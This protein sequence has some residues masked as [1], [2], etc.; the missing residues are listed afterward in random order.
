MIGS[1]RA[2]EY[3]E[4]TLKT[5]KELLSEHM[6]GNFRKVTHLDLTTALEVLKAAGHNLAIANWKG[7]KEARKKAKA[8]N[9]GFIFGMYENK[10]IQQAKTKYDWDCTYDEAHDFRTAY[11]EL[12][13]G[14][15]PWHNKQKTI[16]KIDGQVRNLF[17][18]VRRLPGVYSSD[19]E[20]RG[21]AERQ[22]INSPVQGT[23]GDWKS[24]A[25]VEIEET[26]PTS[27]LRIV[28]E[29][30]DALLMIFRPQYR[31]EVLPRVRAIMR[32]PKLFDEFKIST[33]VPM[34]SE[35][36]IGNWGA[37]K[38]YEDPR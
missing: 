37:G 14:V 34:E 13:Q 20:L 24:A 10:F 19:R 15:I 31:D 25:L 5:A 17:G 18:R 30:H 12:Y 28:G 32:R 3:T 11:F 22:A 35:I 26:I 36:E 4:Q 1:G 27:K 21:E 33:V 8:I 23:I 7:W 38:T 29:H 16:V 9:F 6:F 2:R